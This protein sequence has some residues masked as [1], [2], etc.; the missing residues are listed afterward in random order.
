MTTLRKRKGWDGAHETGPGGEGT[1]QGAVM[2][3]SLKE[4]QLPSHS[5]HLEQPLLLTGNFQDL[6]ES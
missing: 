4:Q 3:V 1:A 5:S 2:G 6:G